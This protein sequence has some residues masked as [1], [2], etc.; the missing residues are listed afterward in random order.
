S[1]YMLK[2][3]R[4]LYED[5]G[6]LK[7]I[8]YYERTLYNHILSTQHP[9]KGGF[10]YFTPLRPGHY[11]VYSTPQECF[12]CCVGSGLENHGKYGELIYAHTNNELFVNLYIASKLNWKEKNISITQQTKFPEEEH[13]DI[14]INTKKPADFV[15]KLRYPGWANRGGLKVK[16]NGKEEKITSSPGSYISINRRWK[17]GDKV[18]LELPMRTTVEEIPDKSGFAAVL[19]G[20]I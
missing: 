18:S 17:N 10:V 16:I 13:S 5:E 12:W 19:H 14:I 15:L 6:N 3:S 8:D 11:R 7:Y 4:M 1:Y 2:L 9:D 20:P